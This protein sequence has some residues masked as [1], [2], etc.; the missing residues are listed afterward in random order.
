[1]AKLAMIA[2][3]GMLALAA[4][5]EAE[6]Q[7]KKTYKS[8]E[9]EEKPHDYYHTHKSVTIYNSKSN[10][11]ASH[12]EW[13][14]LEHV[15]VTHP[16]N[17]Q[18]EILGSTVTQWA[19]LINKKND[20][21]V[22]VGTV[23]WSGIVVNHEQCKDCKKN[24]GEAGEH[25][26]VKVNYQITFEF[27][28]EHKGQLVCAVVA[29]SIFSAEKVVCSITGGSGAFE[30][31]WGT[32]TWT[33]GGPGHGKYAFDVYFPKIVE[34]TKHDLVEAPAKKEGEESKPHEEEE[35]PEERKY[36]RY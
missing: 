22:Q 12:Q 25:H 31:A 32:V 36:Y 23:Y 5:L 35:E 13:D 28:A 18:Y 27:V 34:V 15:Q 14:L 19:E 4:A 3:L 8:Y 1:M 20:M 6:P 21:E 2:L 10:L 9:E 17:P 26:I 7:A 29:E 30:G 16:C 11:K 24:C 33:H